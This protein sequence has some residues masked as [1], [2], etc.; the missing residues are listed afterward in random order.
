VT[1]RPDIQDHHLLGGGT[2]TALEYIK[3]PNPDTDKEIGITQY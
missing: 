3:L 1:L 2:V